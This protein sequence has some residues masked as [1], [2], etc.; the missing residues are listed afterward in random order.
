[1]NMYSEKWAKFT[2]YLKI[3]IEKWAK[4]TSFLKIFFTKSRF[5][6]VKKF[7]IWRILFSKI[8]ISGK[9]FTKSQIFTI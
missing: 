2:N 8:L 1:M 4:F 6:P 9:K 5:A 7:T 3:F